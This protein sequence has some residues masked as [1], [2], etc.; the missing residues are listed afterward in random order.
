[1]KRLKSKKNKIKI[2]NQKRIFPY[3]LLVLL[4]ILII[5]TVFS[6]FF[7]D[8]TNLIT[9]RATSDTTNLS[10]I[11]GNTAPIIES[12]S[13][14]PAQSITEAGTTA[15]EFSFT[16]TDID[17]V[18]N[19]DDTSAKASFNKTGET[20]RTN[21]SCSLVSDV[22]SDTANYTCKILIYYWDGSGD[23]TVNASIE[24]INDEYAE[25]TSTT[26][27]LSQTTAMIMGPTALTWPT[28]LL[29]STNQ[30]SNNDP[31]IINNTANKDIT[32]GNVQVTAIDMQGQ[33]TTTEYL[34][35]GNFTVNTADACDAGTVMVNGT[36]TAVS[37][38]TIPAGNNSAG[39]GQEELYFCLEEV[40]EGIS[41]QT[42]ST[43]GAGAWT[44]G[45]S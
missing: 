3:V 39:Q 9:G 6:S 5:S 17:G 43:A 20:T 33:T 1:M 41:Q 36:A 16:A 28:I 29:T 34:L 25:N 15:V 2:P 22:D 30:L 35:A 11:I 10:I 23:W 14:I 32:S 4:I 40:S 21:S 12:V 13:A 24:D 38:A 19:L 7:Q 26:F 37:G 42:Y 44:I 27:T 45:V 18:G 8:V 31:I